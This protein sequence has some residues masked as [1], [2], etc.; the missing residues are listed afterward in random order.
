M[1]QIRQARKQSIGLLCLLLFLF[2]APLSRTFLHAHTLPDG[3]VIVH[4]H[5]FPVNDD[6]DN[7][8]PNHTHTHQSLLFHHLFSG[9]FD[10]SAIFSGPD[11][12]RQQTYLPLKLLK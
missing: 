9:D 6:S 5:I 7:S 8:N 1:N 4:S 10:L 12:I 3:K 11:L 2:T